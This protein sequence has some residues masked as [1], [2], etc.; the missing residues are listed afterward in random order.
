MLQKISLKSIV[1]Y[2]KIMI[3]VMPNE[4]NKILK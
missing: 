1:K 4:N 2:A 3:N